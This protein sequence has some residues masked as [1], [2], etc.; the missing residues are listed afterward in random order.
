M[1]VCRFEGKSTSLA[2]VFDELRTLPF[3]SKRRIVLVDDADPFVTRYRRELEA[4][5]ASPGGSGTGGGSGILILVLKSWP[6]NTKLYKL[7]EASGLAIDCS[8]PGEKDLVPW[9]TQ[10]A[11]SKHRA[12]LDLDAARLLVELVGAEVGILASEVE[13]LAVYV[14]A[15]A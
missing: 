10:L 4:H 9:L 14:G 3:F 12:H 11:A 2:D 5:A 7:V 13:K 1:A 15:T 6:S 8:S